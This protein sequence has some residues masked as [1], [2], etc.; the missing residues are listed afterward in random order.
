MVR[1]ANQIDTNK[2]EDD[3]AE[4]LRE[5]VS[6]VKWKYKG[7]ELG[8][9]LRSMTK[10]LITKGLEYF[11]KKD[12]VITLLKEYRQW[13]EKVAEDIMEKVRI[14]TIGK[15]RVAIMETNKGFPV[16]LLTEKL[17]THESKPFDII[18]LLIH[19]FKE[20]RIFTRIELRTHTNEDVF[21]IANSLGGGGHKFA[22]G[23]SINGFMG[24]N[25]F[26]E[27]LRSML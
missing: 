12:S 10:I 8:R 14:E 9:K 2:I 5:L 18:A 25:D 1:L 20:N 13:K 11:E 17:L 7:V 16:Y 27:H 23:V 19:G 4:F 26:L 3:D 21:R 6:A 24:A 15:K 22:S